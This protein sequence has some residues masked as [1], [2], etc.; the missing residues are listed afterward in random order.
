[1]GRETVPI[2]LIS[3]MPHACV[4]V[5]PR[6]ARS[7][8]KDGGHAEPPM[9]TVLSEGNVSS[10]RSSSS[11]TA[12]HTVGTP[13]AIDTRASFTSSIKLPGSSRGP[14]STRLAPTIGAMNGTPHAFT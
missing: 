13:S 8:N 5:I 11:R 14:G 9:T 2:G 7:S 4:A 12:S 6:R 1:M 10:R 3:V